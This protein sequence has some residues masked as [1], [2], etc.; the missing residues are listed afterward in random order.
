M[1]MRGLLSSS[2]GKSETGRMRRIYRVT[3]MGREALKRGLESIIR[4]KK[5]M[6]ELADYYEEHFQTDADGDQ[7]STPDTER[8]EER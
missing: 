7:S 1:E 4:R 3:K 8:R 5:M 6:D 2:K